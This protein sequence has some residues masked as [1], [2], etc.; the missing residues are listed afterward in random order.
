MRGVVSIA[1]AFNQVRIFICLLE[2]MSGC[3]PVDVIPT[4][5]DMVLVFNLC[6]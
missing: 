6:K 2:F 4:Y 3:L 1:L 5:G